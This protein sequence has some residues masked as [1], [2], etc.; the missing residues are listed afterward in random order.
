M[1]ALTGIRVLDLTEGYAGPYATRLL[2]MHGAEVIKIERPGCGD[3]VRKR[4]PFFGKRRD[5]R[6]S[7]PFSFL[8]ANKRSL[9][10][11]LDAPAG[12]SVIRG[13]VPSCDLVVES[14]S[15]G[16][17]EA[18]GI[19]PEQ[20]RAMHKGLVVCSMPCCSRR[21]QFAGYRM[22]ELNLY[23]MGGLMSLVGAEGR[24]PLKA[25]GY[26][27]SYMA[28]AHACAISL[29]SVLRARAQGMGAWI[30]API[31]DSTAKFFS[32]MVDFNRDAVSESPEQ[33]RER[34]NAVLPCKGGYVTAMFYYFQ[35]AAIGELLG[36]PDLDSDA[37]FATAESFRKN[38]PVLKRELQRWLAT[39]TAEQAQ[40]EGQARRLLITKVNT[41]LDLLSSPHLRERGFFQTVVLP[42]GNEIDWPGPPFRLGEADVSQPLPAPELGEANSYV[43]GTL[44]G[45][46][47]TDSSCF[48]AEGSELQLRSESPRVD[49]GASAGSRGATRDLALPLAGVRVLDL[50]HRLAGPTLTMMLGDWGADV[51]K[52]EWWHRMDAWRGMIDSSCG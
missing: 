2:A 4:P 12:Q 46:T 22:T 7:I 16:E 37:R 13:L 31:T 3:P 8:N 17:L 11:D 28:G 38:E 18:R 30:E 49:S 34:S 33:H 36:M 44:L 32:H 27:A 26:Q 50:T 52:V 42:D 1:G 45:I 51:I 5:L 6:A 10:L 20:L 35:L 23:A 9:E 14:F 25:G 29:F 43:L 48:E 15:P 39:R 40:Q 21:S 47:S 24:P 19:G 41:P